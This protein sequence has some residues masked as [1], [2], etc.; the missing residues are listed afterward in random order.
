MIFVFLLIQAVII[1]WFCSYVAGQ[2]NR[3]KGSW[4]LL[5]FLF[6]FLAFI[7]LAAIPAIEVKPAFIAD[8][9]GV[10]RKCPFCAEMVKREAIFCRFCQHDLPPVEAK[11]IAEKIVNSA[12]VSSSTD[13]LTLAK[14][15]Q[16]V[17][18][19]DL[20]EVNEKSQTEYLNAIRTALNDSTGKLINVFD[21]HGRTPLMNAI[22]RDD[23]E[24]V[25]AL[26]VAGAKTNQLWKD[27]KNGDYVS[28]KDLAKRAGP[29]ISK[30][31]S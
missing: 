19:N 7:A 26:L 10:S 13:E 12:E 11:S 30:L 6:S 23:I 24:S 3:D 25:K 4:F 29:E 5:G 2:K 15:K 20:R 14:E 18:E 1:G 28:V 21:A 9:E 8:D 16:V 31:F 27:P 22:Q 17:R